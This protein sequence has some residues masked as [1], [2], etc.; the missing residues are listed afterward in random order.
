MRLAKFDS[1]K[2]FVFSS[3]SDPATKAMREDFKI[4]SNAPFTTDDKASVFIFPAKDR[5]LIF[6][7]VPSGASISV[8]A[9]T[10]AEVYWKPNRKAWFFAPN[11]NDV[12]I[13]S[14]GSFECMYAPMW[15]CEQYSLVETV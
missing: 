14:V 7:G 13:T 3:P 5:Y 10:I 11:E 9:G 2:G 8:V 6:E 15:M 4:F 1:T 12:K